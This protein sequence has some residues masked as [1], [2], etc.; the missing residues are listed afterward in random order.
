[1]ASHLLKEQAE[2]GEGK[3]RLRPSKLAVLHVLPDSSSLS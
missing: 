2:A 3:G 1:M